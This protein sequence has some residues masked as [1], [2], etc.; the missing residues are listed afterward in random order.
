M[1]SFPRLIPGSRSR[2]RLLRIR[3]S[4]KLAMFICVGP[5]PAIDKRLTLESLSPGRIHRVRTIQHFPGGKA[6]HV[7]MVLR[8]LGVAPH[9]TGFCGGPTGEELV[10]GLTALGV[11]VHPCHTR[12][13]TRTN[14]EIIEDSGTV[15]EI[16]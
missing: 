13:P 5:N 9:W 4:R 1:H 11:A 14:L 10:R 2:C 6:A 12:Q 7:A 15:T 8:T 16:L 3:R